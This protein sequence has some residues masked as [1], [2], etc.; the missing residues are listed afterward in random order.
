MKKQELKVGMKLEH[1]L[2]GNCEYTSSCLILDEKNADT[3]SA[4]VLFENK[5][6]PDSVVCT[7]G[8]QGCRLKG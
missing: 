2:R 3:S 5:T 1:S 4:Y 8:P 6:E 7:P